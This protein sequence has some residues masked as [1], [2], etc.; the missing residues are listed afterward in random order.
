MKSML[1]LDPF[2]PLVG[3]PFPWKGR[4]MGKAVTSVASPYQHENLGRAEIWIQLDPAHP[5]SMILKWQ[6]GG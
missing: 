5:L 1:E 4:A 6:S 3:H 2:C